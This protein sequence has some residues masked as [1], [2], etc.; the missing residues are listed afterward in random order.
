MASNGLVMEIFH[1]MR[2]SWDEPLLVKPWEDQWIP[3]WLSRLPRCGF[4]KWPINA[5]HLLVLGSK[6]SQQKSQVSHY[7]ILL[8]V[9]LIFCTL[10][11]TNILPWKITMF[12]GKIHYKCWAI[13]NSKLLVHQRV[14]VPN[15]SLFHPYFPKKSWHHMAPCSSS[16]GGGPQWTKQVH[17]WHA[18]RDRSSSH[19]ATAG[20]KRRGGFGWFGF[21]HL[22]NNGKKPM[23][24]LMFIKLCRIYIEYYVQ[25]GW[26]ERERERERVRERER[27]NGNGNGNEN[28]RR[29]ICRST[30]LNMCF[31]LFLFFFGVGG[32]ES[33]GRPRKVVQIL[34]TYKIF[35][36]DV[37]ENRLCMYMD[38]I[39]CH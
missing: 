14:K 4:S 32:A 36:G 30:K 17:V 13:F 28:E 21:E 15:F 24:F 27:E 22:K 10:W 3:L 26:R 39:W 34:H 29:R 38:A 33:V 35:P 31:F 8:F 12:N 2:R 16:P 18:P 23:I 7:M 37:N 9:L 25:V 1:N 11:W 5:N 6:S 19:P 20:A